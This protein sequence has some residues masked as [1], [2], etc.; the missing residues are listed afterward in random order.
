M[1]LT[2]E[3]AQSLNSVCSFDE[4]AEI[5]ISMLA[6]VKGEHAEIVQIC[7]PMSTGGCGDF[8]KNMERFNRSIEVAQVH[9]VAVF[10]QV[11]FQ[12][13]VIKL[14]NWK[15]GSPYPM[16]LLEVFYGRVLSSGH[17]TKGLFLPDWESSVGARWERN[18]LSG[19]G[20][21]I[22]DYPS[23]WLDEAS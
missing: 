11:L 8:K 16:E 20:I 12:D 4:L 22:E 3:E 5:A 13:V 19:L 6:R 23:S 10:N 15:E 18:L 7:G 17:I 2:S 21:A 14:C 1:H 9:G